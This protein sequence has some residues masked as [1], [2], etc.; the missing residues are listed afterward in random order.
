MGTDL[1]EIASCVFDYIV[2]KHKD[3]VT[4]NVEMKAN[5]AVVLYYLNGNLIPR[6]RD[7]RW[8]RH[9][10]FVTKQNCQQRDTPV[11]ILGVGD[12]RVLKMELMR[13]PATDQEKSSS[14]G[15][16]IKVLHPGA[17]KEF[18]IK[19]GCLFMLAPADEQPAIRPFFDKYHPTF[20]VHSVDKIVANQD[21]MSIGIVLRVS[22]HYREVLKSSGQL[23]L[24]EED[25]SII[26][27]QKQSLICSKALK[28]YLSHS[29][30]ATKERK[31]SQ[32]KGTYQNMK[33]RKLFIN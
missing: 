24:S 12:T 31:D 1:Q 14:S 15:K 26:S 27:N 2:S 16:L 21:F 32:I 8:D 10:N 9:A 6:H 4:I 11:V 30:R 33:K 19:H 3:D 22:T 5:T 29:E 25:V 17:T 23:V 28:R 7:T 13:H 20:W 18:I